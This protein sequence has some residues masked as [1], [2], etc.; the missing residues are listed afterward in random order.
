MTLYK[1]LQVAGSLPR[2][3]QTELSLFVYKNTGL[4]DSINQSA[5]SSNVKHTCISCSSYHL[6]GAVVVLL[7]FN[8][9][10]LALCLEWHIRCRS[11]TQSS[12][13]NNTFS[14]IN[15]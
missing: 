2:Q 9:P 12:H 8:V 3:Q 15:N 13:V 1:C 7:Y 4:Q 11:G 5:N 14:K 10:V 6:Y